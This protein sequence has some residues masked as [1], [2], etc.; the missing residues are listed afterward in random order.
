M[1]IEELV[2]VL[3]PVGGVALFMWLNRPKASAADPVKELTD[4]IRGLRER[5][6]R[7]E[8]LLETI[9]GEKK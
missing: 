3:G 6:V 7:V 1:S 4:E 9:V 2:G 8:T 5:L